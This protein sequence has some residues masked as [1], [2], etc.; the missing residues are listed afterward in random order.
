M[1]VFTL[2]T[3]QPHPGRHIKAILL[4]RCKD[5]RLDASL[6]IDRLSQDQGFQAV[7]PALEKTTTFGCYKEVATGRFMNGF[8]APVG[9]IAGMKFLESLAIIPE[10][11]R[12]GS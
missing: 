8:D 10:Q 3:S 6:E 4:V 5:I 2:K 12:L 9:G 1:S 7:A 11:A